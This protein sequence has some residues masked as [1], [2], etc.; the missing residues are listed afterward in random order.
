MAVLGDGGKPG[1]ILEAN[2]RLLASEQ[3]RL[4]RRGSPLRSIVF[5]GDNFYPI[6]LNHE[7]EDRLELVH[8]VI[9]PLVGTLEQIGT[10][11]VHAVPGNH[12]Y[13]CDML[14]PAPYGMCFAG[15]Q[16]EQMIPAWSYHIEPYGHRYP[17]ADGSRDSVELIF[18]NSALFTLTA[19]STWSA[20]TEGIRS[21]FHA[22]A[23]NSSIKWRFI[24][25][26]HPVHTFGEHGGYRVW[27]A[28]TERVRYRGNCIA[29]GK[30]PI[31][32]VERWAG[33]FEDNCAP[34]YRDYIDT[35]AKIV[36]ESGAVVQVMFSG[37][38][39]SL[40]LLAQRKNR[41]TFP[42][43]HVISGAMSKVSRVRTS[44]SDE[45]RGI[46]YFA[47]P[48]NDSISEGESI[49]GFAACRIEGERL[50]IWFLDGER[51]GIA[52]MGGAR[53]FWI[54]QNGDLAET[55]VDPGAGEL[56]EK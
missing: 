32:Y 9:G 6:G 43:I 25:T 11:N 2:G 27:D 52:T 26:H 33:S 29:D 41:G 34:R 36:N 16:Y 51:Q 46:F 38:D 30:D 1:A 45:R 47:H 48:K 15:N 5:L 8:Q 4:D 3:L 44:F 56:P 49:P 14:G 21:L 19:Q 12:D 23:E 22:S 40:Q 50:K 39:H 20:H 37:H 10:A 55:S 24:F 18:L 42:K 7:P 31:K 13:Y 28:E 54:D 53:S 35:L 17:A